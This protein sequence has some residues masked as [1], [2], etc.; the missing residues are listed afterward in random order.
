MIFLGSFDFWCTQLVMVHQII[1]GSGYPYEPDIFNQPCEKLKKLVLGGNTKVQPGLL[2]PIQDVYQQREVEIWGPQ[3]K[4]G[5][6][7]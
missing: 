2:A 6:Q 7:F 5:P 1:L 4:V 3:L